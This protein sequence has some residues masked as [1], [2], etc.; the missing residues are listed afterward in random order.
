MSAM[1]AASQMSTSCASATFEASRS[2]AEHGFAEEHSAQP[3]AVE[4]ADQLRVAVDLDAVS[5]AAPVQLARRRRCISAVIQ[6]P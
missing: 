2:T 6:V 3:H 4:P 1:P 5:E